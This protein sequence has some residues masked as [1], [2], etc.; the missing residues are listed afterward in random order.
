MGKAYGTSAERI[1]RGCLASAR[2]KIVKTFE[3]GIAAILLANCTQSD[4]H[5]VLNCQKCAD[6]QKKLEALFRR[7][8]KIQSQREAK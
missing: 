7:W 5:D 6:M 1:R 3:E 2:R 4:D 8:T